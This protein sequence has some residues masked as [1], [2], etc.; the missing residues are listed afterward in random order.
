MLLQYLAAMGMVS[1]EVVILL[2]T[3][4]YL[5]GCAEVFLCVEV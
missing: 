5:L 1:G 2:E 4:V 3:Q